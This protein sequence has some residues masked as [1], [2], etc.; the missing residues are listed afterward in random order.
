MG[1]YNFVVFSNPI[2]GREEEF[3]RWYDEVHVPQM[4]SVP[5]IHSAKRFRFATPDAE[6]PRNRYLALYAIE[7][8][9]PKGLLGD[10]YARAQDGRMDMSGP[11]EPGFEANLFEELEALTVSR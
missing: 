1:S 10:L 11:S 2:E 4:L 3:N 8:D 6:A 9:D 7:T 5:G